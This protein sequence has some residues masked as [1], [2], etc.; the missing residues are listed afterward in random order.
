M[1]GAFIT[2]TLIILDKRKKTYFPSG[3]QIITLQ[4]NPSLPCNAPCIHAA[5]GMLILT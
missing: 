3:M 5:I 2:I 4:K 1:Q